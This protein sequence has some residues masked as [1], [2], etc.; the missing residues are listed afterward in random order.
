M[1]YFE[2]AEF[3]STALR[4]TILKFLAADP[5]FRVFQL[6][7]YLFSSSLW[8]LFLHVEMLNHEML[9]RVKVEE[10]EED[11]EDDKDTLIES[12]DVADPVKNAVHISIDAMK[13]EIELISYLQVN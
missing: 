9:K 10:A 12:T 5:C 1:A 6:H 13:V 11:G 4:K 8:Q 7:C 2:T 3:S